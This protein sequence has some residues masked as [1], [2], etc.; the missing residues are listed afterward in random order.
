MTSATKR[1]DMETAEQESPGS[2]Q[3]HHVEIQLLRLRWPQIVAISIFWFALNLHWATLGLIILPSQ[4]FK[5]RARSEKKRA[6]AML[7]FLLGRLTFD[8]I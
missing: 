5:K 4:V 2:Q 6:I 7:H 1:G 8:P 3:A